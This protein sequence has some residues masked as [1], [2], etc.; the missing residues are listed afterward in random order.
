MQR[1]EIQNLIEQAKAAWVA[2]DADALV[3]LFTPN[4]EIVVPGQRW[5]GHDRIY[6][7]VTKFAQQHSDVKIEIRQIIIEG[8]RA[9][10]E[11]IYEDTET[12]TGIHNRVEDAI[13]VDFEFGRISRWREYFD[14]KTPAI[15]MRPLG[16]NQIP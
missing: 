4:G 14:T 6:A 3:Q 16:K 5:Q 1:A 13:I 10:V 2:R 12:A 15:K 7:E 9:A 11:W 8:D